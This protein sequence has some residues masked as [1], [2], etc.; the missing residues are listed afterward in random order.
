M[1]VVNIYKRNEPERIDKCPNIQ[2]DFNEQ[3]RRNMSKAQYSQ[4]LNNAH[5]SRK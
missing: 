2:T 1:V 5:Q 3:K 4:M